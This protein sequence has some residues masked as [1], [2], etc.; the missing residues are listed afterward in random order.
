M[1]GGGTDS[2]IRLNFQKIS[3]FFNDTPTI[4]NR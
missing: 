4:N 1:Y 2:E 3:N